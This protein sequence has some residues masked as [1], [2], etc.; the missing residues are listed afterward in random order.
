MRGRPRRS[1][2][3]EARGRN[4][5]FSCRSTSVPLRSGER[6]SRYARKSETKNEQWE[7][8]FVPSPQ[9]TFPSQ[10]NINDFSS[11]GLEEVPEG[12]PCQS[13]L[14]L[15]ELAHAEGTLCVR[16]L[17]ESKRGGGRSF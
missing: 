13:L 5:L 9:D 12:R 15:P 1:N 16:Q 3:F 4:V 11:L 17:G 8:D 6:S 14:R 2:S 7:C 10:D